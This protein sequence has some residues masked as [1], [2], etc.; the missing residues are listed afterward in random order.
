M[1]APSDIVA[2]RKDSAAGPHEA[3]MSDI[4]RHTPRKC[5]RPTF[6]GI[7]QLRSDCKGYRWL[8]A[9]YSANNAK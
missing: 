2:A 6:A 5:A 9:N 3:P 7:G 1:P 8:P 4:S